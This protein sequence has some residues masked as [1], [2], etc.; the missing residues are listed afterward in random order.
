MRSPVFSLPRRFVS[1]PLLFS[2]L[3]FVNYT[4]LSV[5]FCCS[6]EFLDDPIICPVSPGVTLAS[7][8]SLK[9]L[10][11]LPRPLLSA[12]HSVSIAGMRGTATQLCSLMLL[13][14]RES[15]TQISSCNFQKT[16][17]SGPR[18]PL[19]PLVSSCSSCQ[20]AV[21]Q[22]DRQPSMPAFWTFIQ[23][24]S[25]ARKVLSPS[26]LTCGLVSFSPGHRGWH[27]GTGMGS[28]TPLLCAYSNGHFLLTPWILTARW[29]VCVPH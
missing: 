16:L 22:L 14:C 1:L 21:S 11:V 9:V 24:H 17:W 12:G 10:K 2:Y 6:F 26:H 19:R 3:V 20:L 23:A 4:K 29:L 18:W 25:S 5:I 28:K 7:P 13:K 27:L 15:K 8:R